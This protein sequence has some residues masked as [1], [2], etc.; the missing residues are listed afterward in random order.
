MIDL[1]IRK[2]EGLAPL[3]DKDRD[4][5]AA[6]PL[7]TR[8]L[9]RG[10]TLIEEGD[11][12]THVHL[13]VEGWAYRHKAMPDGRRQILGY[14]VP[15]DLCDIHIFVLKRMD[16][17]IGLLSAATVGLIPA[18]EMLKLL[19]ENPRISRALT[20]STLVD[21]ATLREWL[22][23]IGRRDPYTRIAHLL[24]EMWLRMRAVGLASSDE[25]DLP[26][27]Q[28]ELGDTVG[29]T[30]VAVNRV[31]QQLRAEGLITL[32]DKVLTVLDTP[33]LMAASDFDAEYLHR[34]LALE[35]STS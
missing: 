4:V 22:A 9:A 24:C 7:Q 35:R 20:W 11:S 18:K 14:L 10:D 8:S 5:L 13:M 29:L 26:L 25:L 1:L 32:A 33:G 21:E 28:A 16:H 31:L 34:D 30:P 27:T 23:N 12:P 2:L 17:N 6:L 15:G 3:G 19:D